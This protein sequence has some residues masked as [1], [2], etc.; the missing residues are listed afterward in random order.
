MVAR[1]P[2]GTLARPTSLPA[3]S[4]ATADVVVLASTAGPLQMFPPLAA[5]VSKARAAQTPEQR[6]SPRGGQGRTW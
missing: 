6:A 4:V 2:P 5:T 1:I 3:S